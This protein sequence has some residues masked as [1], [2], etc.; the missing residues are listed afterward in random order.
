MERSSLARRKIIRR[1][2][3]EDYPAT[4]CEPCG[5]YAAEKSKTPVENEL[6]LSLGT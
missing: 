2:K 6:D 3:D 5:V 1:P 4:V